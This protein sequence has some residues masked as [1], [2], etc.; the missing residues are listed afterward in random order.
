[1][2]GTVLSSHWRTSAPHTPGCAGMRTACTFSAEIGQVLNPITSGYL[3]HVFYGIYGELL[4]LFWGRHMCAFWTETVSR[5]ELWQH[6]VL[7]LFP[8][9]SVRPLSPTVTQFSSWVSLV[10][11]SVCG[12]QKCL[13][14]CVFCWSLIVTLEL[15]VHLLLARNPCFHHL[16]YYRPS[17]CPILLCHF[18]RETLDTGVSPM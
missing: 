11:P 12:V 10:L 1:M 16:L 17:H 18:S 3:M 9:P 6:E 14:H 15:F 2:K 4:E 8:M 13:F 5:N 7:I